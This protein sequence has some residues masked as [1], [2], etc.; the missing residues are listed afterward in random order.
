MKIVN[1]RLEPISRIDGKEAL[2]IIQ[3]C[4]KT[5]YKSYKDAI[6]LEQPF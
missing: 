5:C 1:A 2:R 6:T 3:R 4:A